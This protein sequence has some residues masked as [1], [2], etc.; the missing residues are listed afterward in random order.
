MA[1]LGFSQLKSGVALHCLNCPTAVQCGDFACLRCPPFNH[2]VAPC[3]PICKNASHLCGFVSSHVF[4]CHS[5]RCVCTI[6][7]VSL[8]LTVLALCHCMCPSDTYCGGVVTLQMFYFHSLR[9]LLHFPGVQ[10]INSLVSMSHFT[11]FIVILW[12]Y[13]MQILVFN[14]H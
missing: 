14:C 2:L 11:C 4:C 3:N 5:L 8:L 9:Y 10:I 7:R 6:I 12:V 1:V 13:S